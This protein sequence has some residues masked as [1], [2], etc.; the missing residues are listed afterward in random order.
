MDCRTIDL[1]ETGNLTFK[2]PRQASHSEAI[3]LTGV[4][5]M[6]QDLLIHPSKRL[7]SKRLKGGEQ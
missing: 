1:A 5:S 3:E 7:A 6:A 4:S 2:R